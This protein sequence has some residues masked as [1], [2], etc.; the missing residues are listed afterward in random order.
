MMPISKDNVNDSL[1]DGL[2]LIKASDDLAGLVYRDPKRFMKISTSIM[3]GRNPERCTDVIVSLPRGL[4]SDLIYNDASPLKAYLYDHVQKDVQYVISRYPP[5]RVEVDRNGVLNDRVV[6]H[7]GYDLTDYSSNDS[8]INS[9]DSKEASE[10][11]NPLSVQYWSSGADGDDLESRPSDSGSLGNEGPGFI[12]SGSLMVIGV[13]TANPDTPYI[14]I[15]F[16]SLSLI[17]AF[18]LVS[19]RMSYDFI[20]K[21]LTHRMHRVLRSLFRKG[22]G[23]DSVRST[24]KIDRASHGGSILLVRWDGDSI[25][26]WMTEEWMRRKFGLHGEKVRIWG[27]VRRDDEYDSPRYVL[28]LTGD[29][30]PDGLDHDEYDGDPDDTTIIKYALALTGTAGDPHLVHHR[31]I[32]ERHHILALLEKKNRLVTRLTTPEQYD[33]LPLL[34]PKWRLDSASILDG[35]NTEPSEGSCSSDGKASIPA[36]QNTYDH[37]GKRGVLPESDPTDSL[38]D[39][40][41]RSTVLSD[42]EKD[43]LLTITESLKNQAVIAKSVDRSQ[44]ESIM[45]TVEGL[46]GAVS[47]LE[48]SGRVDARMVMRDVDK[49]NQMATALAG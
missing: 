32:R 49:M 2:N 26:I 13:S 23:S 4:S 14:A 7:Y 21:R 40:I 44:Y 45:S 39:L 5:S 22:V 29:D 30:L 31:G 47:R 43:R 12:E 1:D 42:E 8:S 46:S 37:D 18:L 20:Q 6:L 17:I 34:H 38:V 3:N 11:F 9:S 16:T 25:P 19:A 24:M 10:A 33:H 27:R 48:E 41:D 28:A 36:S 15:I 35:G